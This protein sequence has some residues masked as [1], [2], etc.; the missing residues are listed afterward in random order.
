ML[1]LSFVLI[2]KK[3]TKKKSRQTR[4]L[5]PFCLASAALCVAGWV[6]VQDDLIFRV[7]ALQIFEL[8]WVA[9]QSTL[10]R[11]KHQF[12]HGHISRFG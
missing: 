8:I 5:R 3:E 10:L 6:L 12:V 11:A 7:V 4:W 1:F 2:Q 9:M